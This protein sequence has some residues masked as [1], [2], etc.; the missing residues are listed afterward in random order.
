MKPDIPALIILTQREHQRLNNPIKRLQT[1]AL[2]EKDLQKYRDSW[3]N[4]LGFTDDLPL[5]IQAVDHLIDL[6]EHGEY[7]PEAYAE[8][9]TQLELYKQSSWSFIRSVYGSI[10]PYVDRWLKV[11]P[12]YRYQF[13]ELYEADKRL[14]VKEQ[15]QMIRSLLDGVA[16]RRDPYKLRHKPTEK[17]LLV[18][19]GVLPD[20]T[21]KPDQ[22]Q[23]GSRDNGKV[24]DFVSYK[25]RMR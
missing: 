15:G 3:I 7:E 4:N 8:V 11:K 13:Q 24:I 14:S 17:Q 18:E 23:S 21:S 9:V 5:L 16:D 10:S 19:L 1:Y 22:G 6:L 25:N 20:E 12:E 2:D